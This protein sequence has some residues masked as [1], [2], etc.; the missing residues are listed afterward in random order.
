MASGDLCN[1]EEMLYFFT[2]LKKIYRN[3]VAQI[4][5]CGVWHEN[6]SDNIYDNHGDVTGASNLLCFKVKEGLFTK[7]SNWIMDE[8]L[9][10]GETN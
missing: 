3:R 9:L 5:S 8:F 1:Q 7:K 6:S 2:R 10:I 4:A